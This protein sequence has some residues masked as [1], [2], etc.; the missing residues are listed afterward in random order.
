MIPIQTVDI[1]TAR[2]WLTQ[3]Q[4]AVL[5]VREEREWQAGH[6]AGARLAPLSQGLAEILP[7]DQGKKLVIMCKSGYRSRVVVEA[8]IAEGVA[9]GSVYNMAGGIKAWRAAGLPIEQDDT[10]ACL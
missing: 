1:H 4:A 8:L 7:E 3:G 9:W 5:D 10:V 2:D 6:I